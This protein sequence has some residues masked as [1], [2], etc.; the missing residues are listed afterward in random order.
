AA[1]Q[2]STL[3]AALPDS[4]YYFDWGGGLVWLAMDDAAISKQAPRLRAAMGEGHATLIRASDASRASVPVFEPLSAPV[5]ALTRGIKSQFDP[6]GV[7]NPGRMY[8]GV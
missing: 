5:M 1:T 6:A 4:A 7:L 2:A 8:E 3:V